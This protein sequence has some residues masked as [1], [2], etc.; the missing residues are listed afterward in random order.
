MSAPRT[1][2]APVPPSAPATD[3]ADAGPAPLD[4]LPGQVLPQVVAAVRAAADLLRAEARRPGGPRGSGESADVD[5]EIER[6]LAQ[7]LCPLLP[8]GAFLG[9]ET[10]ALGDPAAVYRWHVDP[11]DGT[12]PFLRG[13]RGSAVSVGLCRDGLPVLGVVWAPLAPD[14]AGDW[15]AWAEGGPLLRRGV[16]CA[17]PPLPTA[18]GPLDV[19]LVSQH[20]DRAAVANAQAVAPARFRALPSIAWRLALTAAGEAAAATSLAGPWSWDLVGGHALLRA[21]GGEV[22]GADGLPLRYPAAAQRFPRAIGAAPALATALAARPWSGLDAAD[23]IDPLSARYPLALASR[24]RSVS[25]PGMLARAQGCLLGQVAGDALGQLVEFRDADSIAAQYPHGVRALHDGGAFD[26][27]A[28]Q[29]TDDSEMALMLA[30]SI[31]ANGGF[32][33]SAARAAYVEWMRSNPFDIGTT[34]RQGLRDQPT[35]ASQANGALMR[36]SPLA[37][38]GAALPTAALAAW[39]RADAALTHPHP[40]CRDASAAFCVAIAHA[41]RT[42]DGPAAVYGATLGWAESEPDLHPDLLTDLRAAA[43]GPPTDFQQQM[44]WVRVAFRNAFFELLHA[45][46]PTEA[47][48][49]TVG[50]GGDTD[51]NGAIAGAL[52]GA[53]HGR[54]AVPL[55]WRNAVLS[56]RALPGAHQPR[57]RALWAVD[58]MLVAEQLLALGANAA[59]PGT[60]GVP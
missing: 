12:A 50:R 48:V 47:L 53:V 27:R 30:R 25:D 58:V 49:R 44:G 16:A 45:S 18:L 5:A 17:P 29:P 35:A 26:T 4:P 9:E 24:S 13:A 42:G 2:A 32:S 36:M 59:P 7:R 57:P 20:A 8:G 15:L 31:L 60:V 43:A 56:C 10:G 33:A 23:P 6:M 39:A 40:L 46:G 55:A 51:T 41:V 28:G 37:V 3:G 14:D 1:E 34:T 52:L 54:E 11:N 38:Y 19:V 22:V 21:V